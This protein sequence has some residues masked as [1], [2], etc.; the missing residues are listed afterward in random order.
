MK[1]IICDGKIDYS[2]GYQLELN[3]IV[4]C[5]DCGLE[6]EV[7]GLNPVVL[8]KALEADEDWGQ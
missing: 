8:V 3:E 5:P 2:L 1:C 6:Q 7:V 4:E